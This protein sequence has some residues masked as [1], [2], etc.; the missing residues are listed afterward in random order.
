[1]LVPKFSIEVVQSKKLARIFSLEQPAIGKY[2][3]WWVVKG[4]QFKDRKTYDLRILQNLE[5]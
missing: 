2:F 5:F 3:G 1:M 4:L